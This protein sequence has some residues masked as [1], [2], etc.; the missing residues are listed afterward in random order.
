MN[1]H[2]VEGAYSIDNVHISLSAISLKLIV[3]A[4][5]WN[6]LKNLASLGNSSKLYCFYFFLKRCLKSPFFFLTSVSV[7]D[8]SAAPSLSAYFVVFTMGSVP[9]P[10]KKKERISIGWERLYRKRRQW[11]LYKKNKTDILQH[12][13]GK[14]FN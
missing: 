3:K 14:P 11:K 2:F 1:V 9:L 8:L 12:L 5:G 10:G 6:V 4:I 7:P 13:Y